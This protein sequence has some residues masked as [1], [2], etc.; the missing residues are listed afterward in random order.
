MK[1]SIKEIPKRKRGRPATG[2]DPAV[3]ARIPEASIAAIDKWAN[4]NSCTRAEAIR[5]LVELGLTVK[6]ESKPS[7]AARHAR[8][9]KADHASGLA[10]SAIDKLSDESAPTEE[11]AK[12]KRRLISGPA[13]FRDIRDRTIRKRDK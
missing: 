2:R 9:G 11:Q 6:A 4:A 3:T 10:G 7:T 12:R 5:Q 1:R 13:E 8:R